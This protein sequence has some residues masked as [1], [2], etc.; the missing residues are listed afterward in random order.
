M[1]VKN[2]TTAE[3][4]SA[5]WKANPAIDDEE[6]YKEFQILSLHGQTKDALAK[7]QLAHGNTISSHQPTSAI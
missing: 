2:F 3:G 1:P 5:T 7:M 4:G 6:M